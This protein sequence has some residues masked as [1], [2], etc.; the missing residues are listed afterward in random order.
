MAKRIALLLAV[1]WFASGCLFNR[2][3]LNVADLEERV[4]GIEFGK[5]T[6]DELEQM[7]GGSANSITPIGTDR[8]YVYAFG[9][10]KTAGFWAEGLAVNMARAGVRWP[11]S[12]PTTSE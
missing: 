6:L 1:V 9:D 4:K 11:G 2:S 7:L 3:Q 8:L 12:T 10:T 5:T